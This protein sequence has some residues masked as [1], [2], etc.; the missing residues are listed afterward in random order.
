VRIELPYGREPC[1]VDTGDRETEIIRAPT[2]TSSVPPLRQ[3]LGAAL[4]NVPP[5]VGRLTVIVSDATRAEPR[6]AFLEALRRK[7]SEATWTLAI[8]T[9]THGPAALDALGLP[10]W[11]RSL[12]IVNHDGHSHRDIV[13]LG[14]TS[15]GTPIRVHRCLLEADLIVATGCIR[16]HYFAGFGAGV[17]ALFPGLGEAGAIRMNHELKTAQGAVAGNVETNPCRADLEEAVARI[18]TPKL[19]VNGVCDAEGQVREVV[20]GDLVEAFRRGV[21]V[22]LPWFVAAGRPAP[23]VIASDALPVSGSLYQAAKI[24]AAA[25]S[26]VEV[27]GCLVIAAECAGGIEPLTTVNEAVWRLGVLSRLPARAEVRLV[28]SLVEAQV[29]RTLL[30]HEPSV[31]T[32]LARRTGRV[33]IVPRATSVILDG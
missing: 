12:P 16:P 29:K 17:K 3:L 27:G 21:S 15:R 24:A 11:A 22:A 14:T 28:S 7:F 23:L 8:A 10:D 20:V 30:L 33:V 4:A 2:P 32:A 6:G 31:Q 9:G 18:P 13:E 19:L 25:A 1:V 26:L 5:T